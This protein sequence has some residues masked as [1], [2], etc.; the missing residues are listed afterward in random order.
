MIFMTSAEFAAG[1]LASA[2]IRTVDD[3]V[4]RASEVENV[5]KELKIKK[6]KRIQVRAGVEKI[7]A[8][9]KDAE[10]TPDGD[11]EVA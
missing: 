1:P 6:G 9:K 4:A 11:A 2:G 5:L 7:I 8:A 3:C 10:P